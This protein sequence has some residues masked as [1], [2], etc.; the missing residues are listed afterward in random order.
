[1]TTL[2]L[3]KGAEK[4]LSAGHLWVFSN[5]IDTAVT[6]LKG[7]EPGEPVK[8]ERANGQFLG[9]AYANPH[10]L[11]SA[12]ILSHQ[13]NKSWDAELLT[14]RLSTALELRESMHAKPYYRWV[15]GEGDLLPGLVI[16][17]YND[18]V[19]VQI[20]T[21]GMERFKDDIVKA[22][23]KHSNVNHIVLRNDNA[24]RELAWPKNRLVL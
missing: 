8:V 20:N 3:K 16:D 15:H 9:F 19:V 12:R 21:A 23:G 22:L 4:R 13:S 14:Q 7:I 1:V 11:I 5:E 24:I 2:R 17:R 18:L 10:S 6:P